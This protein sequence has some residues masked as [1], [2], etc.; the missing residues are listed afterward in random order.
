MLVIA[1]GIV[2][3]N[4]IVIA[5]MVKINAVIAI[6]AGVIVYN[7]IVITVIVE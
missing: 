3:C 5:E 1:T 4:S 6:V 7:G 2:A